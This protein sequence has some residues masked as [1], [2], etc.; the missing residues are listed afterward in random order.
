MWPSCITDSHAVHFDGAVV[1][2]KERTKKMLLEHNIHLE[3]FGGD[4]QSVCISAL[5]VC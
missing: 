2:V 4:V 5:K 1:V 3:D